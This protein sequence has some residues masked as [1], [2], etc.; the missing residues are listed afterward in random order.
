MLSQFFAIV[1][2]AIMNTFCILML[3]H[4][5]QWSPHPAYA[6]FVKV[7]RVGTWLM[8]LPSISYAAFPDVLRFLQL[9]IRA[10]NCSPA[11]LCLLKTERSGKCRKV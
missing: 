9:K 11:F 4:L 10:Q 1:Y 8:Q 3:Q 7:I 6:E 5:W 2:T